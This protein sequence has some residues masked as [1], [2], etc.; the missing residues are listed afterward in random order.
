MECG[1]KPDNQGNE[2][3]PITFNGSTMTFRDREYDDRAI[4]KFHVGEKQYSGHSRFAS[5][6][7]IYDFKDGSLLSC[8]SL[9]G[10]GPTEF[11]TTSDRPEEVRMIL[12]RIEQA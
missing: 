5:V 4:M 6:R 8:Y 11:T 2:K 3:C 7:G 1:G 9:D 10:D 12:S